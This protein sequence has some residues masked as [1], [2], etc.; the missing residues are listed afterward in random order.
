MPP[1][2]TPLGFRYGRFDI[3]GIIDLALLIGIIAVLI[4]LLLVAL[5]YVVLLLL[6]ILARYLLRGGTRR[7]KF[8]GRWY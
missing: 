8:T 4:V 2:R 7:G 3:Y 5:P 6:L 1:C